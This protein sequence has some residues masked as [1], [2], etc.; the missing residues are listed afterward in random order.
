[1]M[2]ALAESTSNDEKIKPI[3]LLIINLCMYE[4]IGEV[5]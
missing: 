5:N 3:V 2:P 4:G 1:M